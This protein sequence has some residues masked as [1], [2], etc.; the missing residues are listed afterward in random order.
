MLRIEIK[1]MK[2]RDKFFP[3]SLS[4]NQF[5]V[6]AAE[7]VQLENYNNTNKRKSILEIQSY[8]WLLGS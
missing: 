8:F 3:A 5:Y 7:E 6:T 2:L 1:R 4:L